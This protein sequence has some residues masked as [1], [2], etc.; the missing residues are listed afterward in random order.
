MLTCQ[1][2]HTICT[3]LKQP[4][5]LVQKERQRNESWLNFTLSLLSTS[6]I[7]EVDNE[8]MISLGSDVGIMMEDIWDLVNEQLGLDMMD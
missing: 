1:N 5:L 7:E 8:D 4:S 2:Q 6:T 3:P